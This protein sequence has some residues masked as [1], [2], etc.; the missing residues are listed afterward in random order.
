MFL[1][2]GANKSKVKHLGE[3][4]RVKKVANNHQQS[5]I[6]RLKTKRS[7]SFFPQAFNA[8]EDTIDGVGNH[9]LKK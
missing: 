2:R 5:P 9:S 8:F 1:G 4:L 6:N 7:K 3:A